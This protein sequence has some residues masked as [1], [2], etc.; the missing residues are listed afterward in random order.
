M[1]IYNVTIKIDYSITE[2]WL[3]WMK[4]EHMP[5]VLETGCFTS[6]KLFKL[7]DLDE[8][9]GITYCAQYSCESIAD[10]ERYISEYTTVMRDRSTKLFGNKFIAFRT[11]MQQEA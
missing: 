7:L 3:N 10:Y 9:D 5:Q 6:Y 8:T 1:I 11:L 4:E 2:E